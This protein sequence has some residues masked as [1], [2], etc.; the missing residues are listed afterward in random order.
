MC[1][2][3]LVVKQWCMR[4]HA[5]TTLGLG[6]KA[7][8]HFGKLVAR[9]AVTAANCTSPCGDRLLTLLTCVSGADQPDTR[10]PAAGAESTGA[11]G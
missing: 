8:G 4:S 10:V 1:S 7:R 2:H 11:A 3:R 6:H 5:R 9:M